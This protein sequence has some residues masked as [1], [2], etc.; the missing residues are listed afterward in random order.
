MYT[1]A[2]EIHYDA[3]TGTFWG[4]DG[5]LDRAAAQGGSLDSERRAGPVSDYD[6]SG[7]SSRRGAYGGRA[8][9]V[10]GGRDAVA[11]TRG[12]GGKGSGREPAPEL[13]RR[14]NEQNKDKVANHSRKQQAMRKQARSGAF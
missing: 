2:T 12:G 13:L 1:S 14:R 6:G 11:G 4:E 9:G 8:G 5:S 3:E 10:A 7:Q